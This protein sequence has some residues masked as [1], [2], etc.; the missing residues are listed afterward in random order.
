MNKLEEELRE[1]IS[2]YKSTYE[3]ADRRN[4]S[5]LEVGAM[6]LAVQ[7]YE[8]KGYQISLISPSSVFSPKYTSLGDPRDTTKY[9]YWKVKKNDQCFEIHLNAPVWDGISHSA[10]TFVVDVGVV[11]ENSIIREDDGIGLN[12]KTSKSKNY[13]LRGFENNDLVTFMEAK[14]LNIYPM[15]V[16][17]FIGIVHE[18]LPWALGNSEPEGFVSCE[19]FNPTLVSRKGFSANVERLLS[20]LA[21]RKYNVHI[22]PYFEKY[23]ENKNLRAKKQDSILDRREGEVVSPKQWL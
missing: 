14:Y 13:R 17:H 21:E 5:L 1:V 2:S 3:D 15:L 20:S 12:T 4:S 11:K 22:V 19:H 7:H 18:I 9:S 8:I 10:C 23:I 6:L 16:A